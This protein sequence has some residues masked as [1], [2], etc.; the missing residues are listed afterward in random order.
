MG[1][2]SMYIAQRNRVFTGPARRIRLLWK[3]PLNGALGLTLP[4]LHK[5]G[6]CGFL[7]APLLIK[8]IKEGTQG[9][10]PYTLPPKNLISLLP[11]PT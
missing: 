3:I 8:C 6:I 7:N 10:I 1:I 2:R 5:G 4:I 11:A 9:A